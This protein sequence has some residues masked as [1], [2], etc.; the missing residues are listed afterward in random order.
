VALRGRGLGP[1]IMAYMYK[2]AKMICIAL[3]VNLKII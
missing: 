1:S 3:Y 2:N